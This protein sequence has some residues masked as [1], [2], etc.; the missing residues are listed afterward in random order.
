MCLAVL[1][2]DLEIVSYNCSNSLNSI[3]VT[4]LSLGHLIRM[5]LLFNFGLSLPVPE[6][7]SP[8]LESQIWLLSGSGQLQS[9]QL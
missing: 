8:P 1:V 7:L 9:M 2:F 3:W 4:K 5:Q 6:S